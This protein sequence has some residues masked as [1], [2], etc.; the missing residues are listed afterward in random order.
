MVDLT[1]RKTYTA[2]EV[3]AW[4]NECNAVGIEPDM[5]R[6]L[7]ATMQREA[8]LETALRMVSGRCTPEAQ[9]VVD[10]ALKRSN[11]V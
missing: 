8:K 6:Q 7:L 10:N 2:D 1:I 11:E 3:M 5:G 4:L 9:F